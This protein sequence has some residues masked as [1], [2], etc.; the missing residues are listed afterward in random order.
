MK[1]GNEQTMN[2]TIDPQNP[3]N[4]ILYSSASNDSE[5]RR[6]RMLLDE[7]TNNN[8]AA[9]VDNN[10]ADLEQKR[11][12]SFQYF[13]HQKQVYQTGF[14]GAITHTEKDEDNDDSTIARDYEK[15]D[16]DHSR[17]VVHRIP[18][19]V[20]GQET[21]K[22]SMK[23]VQPKE[24]NRVTLSR[25]NPNTSTVPAVSNSESQKVTLSSKN[26]KAEIIQVQRKGTTS[27]SFAQFTLQHLQPFTVQREED[28][29][30]MSYTMAQL[31][32][33]QTME[34]RNSNRR[35]HFSSSSVCRP[36]RVIRIASIT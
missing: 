21:E 25:S 31:E 30:E 2:A 16:S 18:P 23:P 15:D 12:H 28:D 9:T 32:Q 14:D 20:L 17:S 11:K 1:S 3:K 22:A 13:V 36:P 33:G 8:R 26:L 10:N 5:R 7:C 34:A 35:H 19:A 6:E 24:K 29:D 27:N 4:R